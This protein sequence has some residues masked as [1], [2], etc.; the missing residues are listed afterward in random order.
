VSEAAVIGV[1]DTRWGERPMA[2][3]VLKPGQQADSAEIQ[4]HM[5]SYADTGTIPKYAVAERVLF[6]DAIAKTS[7]GKLN[8][9]LLRETYV[10]SA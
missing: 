6:V 2:L 1:P 10:Q 4:R 9:K 8:K 5:K 7:V 3:I